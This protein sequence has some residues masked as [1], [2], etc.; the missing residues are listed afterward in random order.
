LR[1]AGAEV[2]GELT[3]YKAILQGA[4]RKVEFPL[5]GEDMPDETLALVT[6]FATSY[7]SVS[8]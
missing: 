2:L 7:G 5:W 3:R 8:Q 1:P 4:D 6:A